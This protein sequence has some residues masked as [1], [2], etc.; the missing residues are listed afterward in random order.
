LDRNRK[1]KE[2]PQRWHEESSQMFDVV[3]TCEERCF[4]AVCEGVSMTDSATECMNIH[5]YHKDLMLR[6]GKRQRPVHVI[7]VDIRDTHEDAA[8]GG[9]LILQLAQM[10]SMERL[11]KT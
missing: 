9:R 2:A 4:D 8:I 11:M 6:G 3:I 1:I 7:N 10:V 5:A